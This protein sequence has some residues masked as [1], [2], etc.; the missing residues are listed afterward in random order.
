MPAI[1]TNLWFDCQALEAVEYYC[2]V[3]PNSGVDLVTNYTDVGPGP[4]G[5]PVTVDFHLD[6][7]RFTD[8]GEVQQ[9][10][11]LKD[12]YGLSWQVVP[13][14]LVE[15]MADPD[16]ARAAR[17]MAAMMSMEKIDLAALLAAADGDE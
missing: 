11:W 7:T 17:G 14:Q 6:Q 1:I 10:G 5:T 16:P 8:G 3:F 9:C 12:R 4:A 2:S 15:L 13:A